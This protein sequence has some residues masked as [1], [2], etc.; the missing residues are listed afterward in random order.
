MGE[1]QFIHTFHG[2][3]EF[4]GRDRIENFS[5]QRAQVNAVDITSWSSVR[6]VASFVFISLSGVLLNPKEKARRGGPPRAFILFDFICLK[7]PAEFS[8]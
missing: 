8:F 6:S 1:L 7:W 2:E 3:R 5:E 4:P